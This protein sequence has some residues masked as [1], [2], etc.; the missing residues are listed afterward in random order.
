MF[1][2]REIINFKEENIK[3]ASLNIDDLLY[4]SSKSVL[5]DMLDWDDFDMHEDD[6][7][8]I[9]SLKRKQ[10]EQQQLTTGQNTTN[11]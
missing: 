2:H 6:E 3:L 11:A 1:K 9:E 8:Y 4:Y 7:D 5:Q 10:Q